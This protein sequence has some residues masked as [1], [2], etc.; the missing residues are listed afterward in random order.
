MFTKTGGTSHFRSINTKQRIPVSMGFPLMDPI[1]GN[2][3]RSVPC[4]PCL[5]C[6]MYNQCQ[7]TCTMIAIIPRVA[8]LLPILYHDYGHELY[9]LHVGVYNHSNF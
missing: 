7:Y 3:F 9:D 2:A 6:V 1:N 4:L 5:H 8:N